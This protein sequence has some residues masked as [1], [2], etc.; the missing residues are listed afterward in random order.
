M[1]FVKTLLLAATAA[2]ALGMIA[3][4]AIAQNAPAGAPA[5]TAPAGAAPGGR[6]GRG[7]GGPPP[8]PAIAW[9]PKKTRM[10][11]YDSQTKPVWHIADILASH[12]KTAS[13][14]QPIVRNKEMWAD[15]IQ[16]AAGSKTPRAMY[17]D[18]RIGMIVWDGQLRVSVDGMEPY[19]ATKGFEINIPY[20]TPYTLEAVGDKPALY[21]MVHEAEMYPEYPADTMPDKPKDIPGYTYT[22]VIHTANKGPIKEGQ[23]PYLDYYKDVVAANGRGGAFISDDHFFFNNIRGM[24]VPTPPDTNLGHFHAEY[25]EFW[26]IIEGKMEYKIEGIRDVVQADAGDVVTAAQGRFHRASFKAGQMDT[27]VAINPFPQG[28]HNFTVESGGTQ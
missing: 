13:W 10:T 4:T 22:K 3:E 5:A 6:G 16:L 24:G 19:I 23:K 8:A 27:R 26:F 12:S 2:G 14:E 20:R 7:R 1:N 18:N 11:P 17:P 28:Q 15:Y 25:T 9:V 21:F